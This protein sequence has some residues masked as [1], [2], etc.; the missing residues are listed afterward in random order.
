MGSMGAP[1]FCSNSASERRY[2]KSLNNSCCRL[3]TQYRPEGP[4]RAP[5]PTGVWCLCENNRRP[6]PSMRSCGF[7]SKSG[8]AFWCDLREGNFES[9]K[10]SREAS[11]HGSAPRSRSQES[12]A[13]RRLPGRESES[14][15][16]HLQARL[17][18][19]QQRHALQAQRRDARSPSDWRYRLPWFRHRL[20]PR[21]QGPQNGNS[22]LAVP[23][24]WRVS[25]TPVPLVR[26]SAFGAAPHRRKPLSGR[27]SHRNGAVRRRAELSCPRATTSITLS[28][29]MARPFRS[30][31]NQR[32]L[33][34]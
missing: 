24:G 10:S 21:R 31:P 27:R 5:R 9:E 22:R 12:R 32:R 1:C 16:D 2:P 18:P 23:E 17:D 7:S 20:E 11:G 19:A 6:K 25:A 30:S 8:S 34:S 14:R 28:I 29:G 26:R 3:W 13:H 15:P 33:G 4:W